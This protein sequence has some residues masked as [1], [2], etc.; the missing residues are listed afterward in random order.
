MPCVGSTILNN[1]LSSRMYATTTQ[2][3][4]VTFG[5]LHDFP[6][7]EIRA[8]TAPCELHPKGVS[9]GSSPGL[10]SLCSI[11]SLPLVRL[12]GYLAA[13][14]KVRR[15]SRTLQNLMP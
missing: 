10:N 7:T 5:G 15:V 8:Q 3:D 13:V 4:H 1:L 12:L 2:L 9:V 14:H 6:G 11:A